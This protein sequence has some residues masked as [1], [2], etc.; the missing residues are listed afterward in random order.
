MTSNK[1]TVTRR[2]AI[3]SVGAASLFFSF[4]GIATASGDDSNGRGE[5]EISYAVEI[6][7]DNNRRIQT[8]NVPADWFEDLQRARRQ[9]EQ[10][11]DSLHN[12]PGVLATDLTPGRAGGGN[13]RINVHIGGE[14]APEARGNIPEHANGVPFEII[15][16]GQPS[17]NSGNNGRKNDDSGGSTTLGTTSGQ[18]DGVDYAPD[19]PGGVAHSSPSSDWDNFSANATL[20]GKFVQYSNYSLD[21]YFGSC[22][23]A[24]N[25]DS[26]CLESTTAT[27][28]YGNHEI[29]EVIDTFPKYDFAII[30][31]ASGYT[32]VSGVADASYSGSYTSI[33]GYIN[34]NG[35]N[36]M[37]FNGDDIEF[38]GRNSCHR[39][40]EIESIYGSG[41]HDVCGTSIE[42]Q[43]RFGGDDIAQDGDSGGPMYKEDNGGDIYLVGV[44][45]GKRD[46]PW[47][48]PYSDT[49]Y[50]TAIYEIEESTDYSVA[51]Y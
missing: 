40:G 2:S 49:T 1:D 27:H 4:G 32:P 36:Y 22:A 35:L 48:S 51:S 5:R 13:A 45:T 43:V 21:S 14:H 6:D 42:D 34:E 26:N 17:D 7:E 12:R 38:M 19:I 46:S 50:G 16:R 24:F 9:L 33:E 23:H 20:T 44:L 25:S 28:Y 29:G 3:Q 30:E 8:R 39:S 37:I 18:C 47:W 31:P 41:Y 15:D 10:N 11:R